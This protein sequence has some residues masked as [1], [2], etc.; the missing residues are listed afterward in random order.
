MLAQ[1]LIRL[2][3]LERKLHQGLCLLQLSQLRQELILERLPT[4]PIPRTAKLLVTILKAMT[5]RALLKPLQ[6]LPRILRRLESRRL[7]RIHSPTLFRTR[8]SRQPKSESEL[9]S[10][11]PRPP[12]LR[13]PP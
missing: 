13:L 1:T 7:N 6:R 2:I 9:S 3:R 5:L 8:S 11:E 4:A 10:I 12:R